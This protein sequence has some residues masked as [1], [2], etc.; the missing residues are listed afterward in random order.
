MHPA[1]LHWRQSTILTDGSAYG[2]GPVFPVPDT[3]VKAINRAFPLESKK[4][5]EL[6]CWEG[7]ST[8]S[9]LHYGAKVQPTDIREE[10]V[11]R[12]NFRLTAHGHEITPLRLNA[13]DVGKHV[14]L[15]DFDAIACMGM[16]YHLADPVG[17]LIECSE[18][19][20]VLLLDTHYAVTGWQTGSER[21][22]YNQMQDK[23]MHGLGFTIK[24]YYEIDVQHDSSGG[25]DGASIW[26]SRLS[27]FNA[28]YYAG[29]R[30][31]E[32]VE[33]DDKNHRII[34]IARW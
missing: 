1:A 5:L 3:R 18:A 20:S 32:V 15:D 4:V 30:Q 2:N 34:L 12:T 24:T 33:H 28:I 9:F 29:Y 7:A 6:G 8:L 11:V 22:D 31:I 25:V 13:M 17:A 27:L 19:C 14:N 21:L 10:N 26:L 23:M 16:L